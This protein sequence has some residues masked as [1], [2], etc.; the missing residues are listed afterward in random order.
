MRSQMAALVDVVCLCTITFSRAD[1]PADWVLG[2]VAVGCPHVRT[3]RHRAGMHS[4]FLLGHCFCRIGAVSPKVTRSMA[5]QHT[6]SSIG[7]DVSKSAL[8]LPLLTDFP[9]HLQSVVS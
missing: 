6:L 8:G 9:L 5:A 2:C 3:G 7:V 4:L 1:M